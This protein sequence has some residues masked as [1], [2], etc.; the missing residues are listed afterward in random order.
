MTLCGIA[1][2]ANPECANSWDAT[3]P[4]LRDGQR[5]DAGGYV[6]EDNKGAIT[7]TVGAGPGAGNG[8]HLDV[9]GSSVVGPAP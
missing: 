7:C 2:P 3:A 6:C 1:Q 5:S 8:F 4:V 9:N